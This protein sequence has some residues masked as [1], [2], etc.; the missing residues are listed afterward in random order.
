MDALLLVDTQRDYFERADLT[1]SADDV[2]AAIARLLAAFRARGALVLHG[3]T[4]VADDGSD[5]MPHWRRSG[6]IWCRAG[7]PGALAPEA[8]APREGE[9][10]LAKRFYSPFENGDLLGL[11]R[12]RRIDRL[13]IAGLYTHAC[14]RS[15]V[16]DGYTHGLEVL[17]PRDAV[18]SYD[19]AHAAMTLDWLD[20]R[21]AQCVTV[22]RILEML[23]Q[24]R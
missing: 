19:P 15:A 22:D 8:L 9:P 3:H 20:G 6:R 24:R 7:S 1:P 14:V 23:G 18:A 2:T 4:L 10:L 13:V 21:A 16:L 11:L 17:L 5:A 12:A